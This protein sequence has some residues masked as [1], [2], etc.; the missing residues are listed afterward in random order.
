MTTVYARFNFKWWANNDLKFYSQ[1][2]IDI[3]KKEKKKKNVMSFTLTCD[4]CSL[5]PS[6]VHVSMRVEAMVY[7][8]GH[9]NMVLET[10]VAPVTW[11]LHLFLL[12]PEK[13]TLSNAQRGT[14]FNSWR[15]LSGGS[16]VRIVEQRAIKI[17]VQYIIL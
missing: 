15:A 2:G 9:H 7:V 4:V 10:C 3:G 14:Y 16:M 8:G 5:P 6:H 13:H 17:K 12:R 11:T 1:L